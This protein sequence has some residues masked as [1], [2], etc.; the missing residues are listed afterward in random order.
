[1][2]IF[3]LFFVTQ[4]HPYQIPDYCVVSILCKNDNMG[5]NNNSPNTLSKPKNTSST[6]TSS[7]T[8]IGFAQITNSS[9]W[10]KAF[11]RTIGDIIPFL[12]TPSD[13]KVD[14]ID[15]IIKVFGYIFTFGII[16]KGLTRREQRINKPIYSL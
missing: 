12:S 15:Y 1:M 3:A 8:F 16:K 2:F 4:R 11:V 14:L 6:S 10:Q 7:S 5:S 9:Q 13:I